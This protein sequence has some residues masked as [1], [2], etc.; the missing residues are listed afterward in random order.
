MHLRNLNLQIPQKPLGCEVTARL[1]VEQSITLCVD[2]RDLHEMD[3]LQED[4]YSSQDLSL[5]S[6][7]TRPPV[8]VKSK[9]SPSEDTLYATGIKRLFL[10]IVEFANMCGQEHGEHARER[11]QEYWPQDIEI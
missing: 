7:G 3:V 2:H 4:A 1:L 10:W 6:L 5:H 8:S 11:Y 9:C